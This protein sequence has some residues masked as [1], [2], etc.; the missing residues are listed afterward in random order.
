[1]FIQKPSGIGQRIWARFYNPGEPDR[2]EEIEV[3]DVE[4]W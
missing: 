4:T 3:T 1:M 2:Y